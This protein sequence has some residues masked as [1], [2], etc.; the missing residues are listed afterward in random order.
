[1]NRDL[2]GTKAESKV[3]CEVCGDK[4]RGNNF[5]AITCAS[6]KEFFRRN[7]YKE[8]VNFI[9]QLRLIT[10]MSIKTDCL[11]LNWSEFQVLLSRK[12]QN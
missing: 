1:M 8:K 7:A 3:V 12:L 10:H 6:C 5:D 2:Y 4:A 11:Y 9:Y